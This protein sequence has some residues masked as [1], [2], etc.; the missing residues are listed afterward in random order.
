MKEVPP[1]GN[2]ACANASVKKV[3]LYH[4]SSKFKQ[5]QLQKFTIIN[6]SPSNSARTNCQ[7]YENENS[8]RKFIKRLS[9]MEYKK[10]A[11][12]DQKSKSELDLY[13]IRRQMNLSSPKM[14]SQNQLN[15]V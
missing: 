7:E 1:S 10:L 9:T 8:A 5:K 15:D 4:S 13:S 6:R 12:I 14:G 11:E 3:A 2:Q